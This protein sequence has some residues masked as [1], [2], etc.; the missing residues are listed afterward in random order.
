M[1]QLDGL[2]TQLLN[3]AIRTRREDAEILENERREAQESIRRMRQQLLEE[4]GGAI[5]TQYQA[6]TTMS[7]PTIQAGAIGRQLELQMDR[8]RQQLSAIADQIDARP[9]DDDRRT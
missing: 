1:Q 9:D 4:V 7:E 6:I 5:A 8:L 3:L 2:Q